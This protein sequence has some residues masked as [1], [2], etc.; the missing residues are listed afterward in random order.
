MKYANEHLSKVDF[1]TRNSQGRERK[2]MYK[3]A[4]EWCYKAKTEMQR[5]GISQV[6]LAKAIGRTRQSV[7]KVLNGTMIC[8]PAVNDISAYLKISNEY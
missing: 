5:Q 7:S 8:Q 2:G 3:N 1:S 6:E 4:S